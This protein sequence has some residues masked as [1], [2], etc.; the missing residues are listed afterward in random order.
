MTTVSRGSSKIQIVRKTLHNIP[1]V[2]IGHLDRRGN[3]PPLILKITTKYL[4]REILDSMLKENKNV[5]EVI[6]F[7]KNYN[8]VG[9]QSLEPQFSSQQLNLEQDDAYMANAFVESAIGT[10]FPPFM[11]CWTVTK[12]SI[13]I[14][15]QD[16]LIPLKKWWSNNLCNWLLT[17]GAVLPVIGQT[18]LDQH[19]IA[20]SIRCWPYWPVPH[21]QNPQHLTLS[22]IAQWKLIGT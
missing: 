8:I 1:S 6:E 9:H 5:I 4:G 18:H 11:R 10:G 21:C 14:S 16:N 3:N 17:A 15:I 13:S 12:Y 19:S 7:F 20:V 2:I 22:D